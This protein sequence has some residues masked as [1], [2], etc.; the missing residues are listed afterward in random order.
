MT[1]SS[2]YGILAIISFALI[3]VFAVVA[4]VFARRMTGRAHVTAELGIG[5]LAATLRKVRRREPLSDDELGLARQVLAD[6]GS[7]LALAVPA[8]L[9]CLGCF[10]VFGSLEQLHG[11]TPSERT[12]LGVFPMLTSTNMAIQILR[13]ARLKRRLPKPVRPQGG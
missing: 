8:T 12:F 11:R 10:Y 9:F 5:V 2:L 3:W 6:R 13:S 4:F 7:V 1:T